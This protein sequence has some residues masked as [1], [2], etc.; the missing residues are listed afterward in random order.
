MQVLQHNWLWKA[1]SLVLAFVL[2]VFVSKQESPTQ[3]EWTGLPVDIPVPAGLELEQP[4]GSQTV[5]VRIQGPSQLLEAIHERDLHPYVPLEGYKPG[6]LDRREVHL[7]PATALEAHELNVAIIPAHV[8]IQLEARISRTFPLT[9]G[10]D[11]ALPEGWDWVQPPRTDV[12][13]VL[14]TGLKP[15]V[16]RVARVVAD[17]HGLPPEEQVSV[18]ATL[19]A[20]DHFGKE[21]LDHL[22]LEPTQVPVQA[23]LKRRYWHKQV[24]V[25]PIFAAPPGAHLRVTVDPKRVTLYGSD[26]ALQ[27][28]QVIE[29]PEISVPNGE[30]RLSREVA[31]ELGQGVTRIDPPIVRVTIEQ[32]PASER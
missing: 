2:Y 15:V 11:S 8:D 30:T 4:V 22:S 24:L 26:R 3:R 25:Q 16:D 17:V 9:I 18:S 20:E 31:L 14:V 7:K 13:Q 6:V 29:T 27:E 21:V 28:L 19:H 5:T 23:R 32:M 1:L 12:P 10:A